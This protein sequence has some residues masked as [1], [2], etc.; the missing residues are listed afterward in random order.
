MTRNRSCRN[1][2]HP[3]HAS[4]GKAV[5]QIISIRLKN[6]RNEMR[7]IKLRNR[8]AECSVGI[9]VVHVARPRT[10]AIAVERNA[11]LRRGLTRRP[12]SLD[13]AY[14]AAADPPWLRPQQALVRRRCSAG[15]DRQ[16]RLPRPDVRSI[17]LRHDARYLGQ[18]AEV[19][20]NPG[21][22]ELLHCH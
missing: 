16:V 2:E 6:Q 9:G 14:I 4:R 8:P 13:E 17:L 11:L 3:R 21:R 7:V 18:V 5:Y 20:D 15:E 1:L 19:M 10:D 12:R 22:Q